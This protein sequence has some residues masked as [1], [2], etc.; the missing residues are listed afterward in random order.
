[1]LVGNATA[2][3]PKIAWHIPP[4]LLTKEMRKGHERRQGALD[5]SLAMSR[6]SGAT[7]ALRPRPQIYTPHKVKTLEA[8]PILPRPRGLHPAGALART[9]RKKAIQR[10]AETPA[11]TWLEARQRANLTYSLWRSIPTPPQSRG[12]LSGTT[13]RGTQIKMENQPPPQKANQTLTYP[14]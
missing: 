2:R 14:V 4:L 13:I 3:L 9:P 7:L 1:M 8:Y 11:M 12:L 10:H 5:R 6:G